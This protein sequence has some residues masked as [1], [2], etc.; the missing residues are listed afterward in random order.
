MFRIT[1]ISLA[2]A[3]GTLNHI[4][5]FGFGDNIPNKWALCKKVGIVYW[6][7]DILFVDPKNLKAIVSVP[8]LLCV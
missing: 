1:V 4:S 7:Y 6:W 2:L 5:I 8:L 3:V